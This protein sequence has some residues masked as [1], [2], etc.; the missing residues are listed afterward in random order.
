[1][2]ALRP[3]CVERR[4]DRRWLAARI[5]DSPPT[6]AR[7]Y[8]T[9][10]ALARRRARPA[11]PLQVVLVPGIMGS[12]LGLR[13]PS[14]LPHDVLWVDPIDIQLGRLAYLR[15]PARAPIVSLGVVLFS[16]LRLKLYLRAQ[17]FA[18]EFHDYDW[19]LPVAQLGAALAQRLRAAVGARVALVAHSMGGLLARIAL[20]LPGTGL[21][22]RVVLLGTP[23]CGSFAA[24]QALRGTYAVVRKVGAHRDRGLRRAPDGAGIQLLPEPVR[25]AAVGGL[26]QPR[27]SV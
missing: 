4:G 5:A 2:Y 13:R 10:A 25:A 7:E 23:N 19:R 14:P 8:A 15:L 20:G 1:M 26:R 27:R 3:L 18:V 9:L 21:V 11:Q 12:Q 24:V 6:G 22:E 17:G 16:H